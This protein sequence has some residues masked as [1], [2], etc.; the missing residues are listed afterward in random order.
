DF[1]TGAYASWGPTVA[2]RVPIHCPG[3]YHVPNLRARTRAVLT[4]MAP[5][6][7]FRGFGVP[8]CALVHEALMDRLAAS[9]GIDQLEFR[10]INA[11]RKGDEI[12][13]GYALEASA[14]QAECLEALRERWA[15]WRTAADT[16]NGGAN[17]ALRRGVGIGSVW[18]GCGNTS[19]SNPSTMHVGIAADGTVTLYTGA[20]DIGEGANTVMV[21]IAADALGIAASQF[22]YIM[23]DTDLTADA[24]KTSGSRQTY[25]SG[26]AA[27]LAG[28]DLRA[29]I[30]RLTNASA[31]AAIE[32][33]GGRIAVRDGTGNHEVDLGALAVDARG[34]VLTGE[35]HFDPPTTPLD[36]NGQGKPYGT[37]GFGAQ[38]AQVEVDMELGTVKVLGVAAAHDVGRAINTQQLEGQIHGGVAQ[39]LGY[40]LMEEYLPGRTDNLHDYLIPTIGDLPPIEVILV[41]DPEPTGPFGAKGIG[42]HSLIPTAPAI[43]G[44]IEHAAGIRMEQLPATP[45]RV[46]AAIKARD[47]G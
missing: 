14:G 26:R 4:N 17:G 35:G 5:S 21:Q 1:D 8:Q 24:G 47:H 25:V 3:P 18:Y 6:G 19:I 29:R 40:A 32:V 31:N 28:E 38:V 12:S 36:E 15:E 2:D 46:R 9:T 27:Q 23:G 16:Y 13:T 34:S 43:L 20:V 42:E 45:H 44:A 22:R 10:H 7:A 11:L 33:A 37:F 30:L 41:E 39:G